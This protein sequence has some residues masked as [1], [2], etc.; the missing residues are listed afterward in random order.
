[1][2]KLIDLESI[3]LDF[4]KRLEN[5]AKIK[6]SN[7]ERDISS[8]ILKESEKAHRTLIKETISKISV[9]SS[10]KSFQQ[11]DNQILSQ[12]SKTISNIITDNI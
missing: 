7:F 8:L 12:L 11:T 6:L 3:E 9:S 2:D 5:I 4:E 10:S 1:M